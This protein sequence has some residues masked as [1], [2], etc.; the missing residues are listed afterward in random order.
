M[1]T[2]TLIDDYG[3]LDAYFV[4]ELDVTPEDRKRLQAL[5]LEPSPLVTKNSAQL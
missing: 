3:S 2:G 5:Y 1:E 4:Q